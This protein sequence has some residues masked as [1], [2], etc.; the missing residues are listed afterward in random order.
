VNEQE[1]SK[2][3]EQTSQKIPNA[4]S[5]ETGQLDVRFIL[6]RKFCAEEGIP[7]ETLPSDL[8]EEKRRRW[9]ELKQA[10]LS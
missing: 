9:E 1:T 8:E 5:D 3:D 6:W 10:N 2:P 7:V 4:V